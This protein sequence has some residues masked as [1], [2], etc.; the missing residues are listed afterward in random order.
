MEPLSLNYGQEH[1]RRL[2]LWNNDELETLGLRLVSEMQEADVAL[3]AIGNI[4]RERAGQ[5][6]M[7]TQEAPGYDD[8]QGEVEQALRREATE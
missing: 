4:F 2:D 1:F 6:R 5:Q 7:F 3:L 8:R